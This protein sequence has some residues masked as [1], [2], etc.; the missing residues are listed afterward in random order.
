LPREEFTCVVAGSGTEQLRPAA[1]AILL[2]ERSDMPA[3]FAAGDIVVSSSAF[4][5]GFS[6]VIAE[7]M[8]AGLPA[9]VTDVG[10]A[11]RI[12]GDTGLVCSPRDPVQLADAIAQMISE[13]PAKRNAQG[14]A[15]R[16][17]IV[18]A[19]SLEREIL[20]YAEAYRSVP[21]LSER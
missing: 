3:V 15:A 17:R 19:F 11:R 20:A 21:A 6:N 2:G 10:D 16:R 7:G 13:P 8:A 18:E 9:V 12:V 4:G 5:E 1:P 14:E